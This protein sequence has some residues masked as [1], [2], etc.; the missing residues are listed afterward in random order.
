MT[1]LGI[2]WGSWVHWNGEITLGAMLT[3]ATFVLT[4][5]VVY[6]KATTWLESR[7]TRFETTLFDHATQLSK[8]AERMDRYESRY[9]TIASDLQ[10]LIGRMDGDR[11]RK[12]DA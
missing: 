5:I 7:F 10:W 8:H 12:P 6:T 9:V 11:R 4:V 2:P 3:A 1:F